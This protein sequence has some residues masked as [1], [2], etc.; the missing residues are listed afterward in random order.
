MVYCVHLNPVRQRK[1]IWF[2]FVV[3]SVC[4]EGRKHFREHT[5]SAHV[6]STTTEII[7]LLYILLSSSLL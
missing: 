3:V 4:L 6:P 5:N 1:V 7:V 2:C